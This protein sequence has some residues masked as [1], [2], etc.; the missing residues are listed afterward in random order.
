MSLNPNQFFKKSGKRVRPV[1]I[2]FNVTAALIEKTIFAVADHSDFDLEL[3][4][5]LEVAVPKLTKKEIE[6]RLRSDL[7]YYGKNHYDYFDD[8]FHFEDERKRAIRRC[9][10]AAMKLYPEFYKVVNT[11]TGYVV[12]MEPDPAS[13]AETPEKLDTGWGI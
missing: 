7:H 3:P 10:L 1:Q 6:K 12:N 4:E 9:K 8:N 5:F 2:K 11:E 13:L